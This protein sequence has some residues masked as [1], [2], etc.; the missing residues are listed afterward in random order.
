MRN[1]RVRDKHVSC[2][3]SSCV[4]GSLRWASSW[5]LGCQQPRSTKTRAASSCYIY[6]FSFAESGHIGVSALG[7]H[8]E[9]KKKKKKKGA[10]AHR[11][12]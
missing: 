9:E 10:G 2:S 8:R 3:T 11:P 1:D 5:M 6:I 7:H 4:P 12:G